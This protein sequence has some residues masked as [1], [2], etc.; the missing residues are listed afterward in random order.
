M[1]MNCR[2]T[3][4][5]ITSTSRSNDVTI[6]TLCLS[7]KRCCYYGSV[8]YKLCLGRQ[9]SMVRVCFLVFQII[10]QI[11][12]LKPRNYLFVFI[13]IR[14]GND[15]KLTI[16]STHKK[17]VRIFSNPVGHSD[18]PEICCIMVFLFRNITAF[19]SWFKF[20]PTDIHV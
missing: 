1:I 14:N 19:L 4:I 13:I 3:L 18:N 2:H 7:V 10:L 16:V 6:P 20:N 8:L 15:L 5:R 17:G 11:Y 9:H 12:Q